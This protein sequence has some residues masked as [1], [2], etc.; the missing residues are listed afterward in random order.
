MITNFAPFIHRISA[1]ACAM[2][3]AITSVY[4]TEPATAW[5]ASNSEADG[6]LWFWGSQTLTGEIVDA[7]GNWARLGEALF[8]GEARATWFRGGAPYKGSI[9]AA[10]VGPALARSQEST[11][12]LHVEA[13]LHPALD[14]ENQ[15][16]L[17]W[18]GTFEDDLIW[19]VLLREHA[20]W[21]ERPDT[22]PLR[23]ADLTL[24]EPIHFA[25][26]LSS[27]NTT[28]WLNGKKHAALEAAAL[29]VFDDP[30][31]VVAAFGGAPKAVNGWTGALEYLLIGTRPHAVAQHAALWKTMH[32]SR[33]PPEFRSV[34]ATLTAH[35]REA[36]EEDLSE[37]GNVLMGMVWT[38]NEGQTE[39]LPAND[40][41]FTWHFYALDS[42][43]PATSRPPAIGSTRTFIM[44]PAQ[45]HPQLEGIQQLVEDIDPDQLLL[46][47]DYYLLEFLPAA[48]QN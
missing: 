6:T 26:T 32:D 23:I 24:N 29:P 9:E 45:K 44:S 42:Q 8:R 31:D 28:V 43:I 14:G 12:G 5:P 18:L 10:D 20:L 33:T 16:I 36:K 46:L 39:D 13:A 41:F 7:D 15:G 11:P 30:W 48:E 17:F 3:F 35:A 25:L 21:I 47:P 19:Q 1:L 22:P 4:A 34:T 40:S 38:L 2:V 37:Y 27:H